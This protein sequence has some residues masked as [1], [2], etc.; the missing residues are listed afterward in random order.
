MG[1]QDAPIVSQAAPQPRWMAAPL[2]QPATFQKPEDEALYRQEL[3]TAKA[4]WDAPPT[5]APQGGTDPNQRQFASPEDAAREAVI[6]QRGIEGE[7]KAFGDSRTIPQRAADTSKFL[8]SA[9]IRAVTR[10]EYGVGDVV[11]LVSGA[12]KEDA[13]TGE[14]DFAQAN[15]GW[16]EPL[17]QAGEVAAA[18][19]MLRSMGAVPGGMMTAT[20]LARANQMLRRTPSNTAPLA[21]TPAQAYGPAA[22]VA[23]RAAFVEEGIPEFAPAFGSKGLARTAKTI[24][25][26]PLVGGTVKVPKNAVE[27][28][29]A[30]RQTAIARQAGPELGQEGVG[31]VVQHGLRRFRGSDLED[32]ERSQVQALGLTPDRPPMRTQGNVNVNRPSQLN[33]ATMSERD[34]TAAAQSRVDLPGSTRSRIEDLTPAEVTRITMLPARDTSFATKA[35]ALYRQ[36]E[37]A[38]PAMMRANET[39]NPGLFAT[40]NA[41]RV[42]NGLM[43]QEQ[44]AGISGGVLEG[45]FGEMVQRLANPRSNFTLDSLRAAR[46]EVG[47]ALSNF[48]EFDARLDRTQMKQLYGA[49]S[50][51]YQTGLVALA[52]R[53]RARSRL[54]PNAPN[55]VAP[56]VADAADRALHRYRVADRYYRGGIER[57]DRFM[58]VLGAETLEQ[59]SR[60][61]GSYLKENTQN[62][63]ALESMAS[64]LR[65]EEWRAVLGNVVEG[66]GRLTPGSRE[67]EKIFSFERYATDWAKISQNPRTVALF[68]RSLGPEVVRSLN[69]MGRIAERM[70][71]YET[72]KNY[73]G[74]AYTAGVGATLATAWNPTMWPALIGAVAGTGI[75]GKVLTSKWFAAW[76][77]SLNRAQVQVGSSVAATKQV[78]QQH[79]QRLKLLATKEPD[80]EVAAAMGLLGIAI[81]QQ[82]Q[83]AQ[84]NR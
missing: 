48:G 8:L 6:R 1:W 46:T 63:R 78:A 56:S 59:A 16:L 81:E 40:R 13:D 68:E 24:E 20:R 58:G 9:P 75:T 57:M 83:A 77:N 7:Q 32:L 70:K 84:A 36:A 18:V 38:V 31:D 15:R 61:I 27:Q 65:P 4:K 42:A 22:R 53:A 11:G 60:K 39:A 12:M 45:R 35:S 69:N 55:Y 37:D 67:A 54:A 66:L 3:A 43:R 41:G 50:D 47:R 34:L 19:P 71:Y 49:I 76:V 51:D 10:G 28:A 14:A 26:A 5:S 79:L 74:S 23:D 52:A 21:A 17:A 30:D 64:S 2:A 25:E 62:I 72:T 29:M 82:L 44:S 80:P 33:T 73:S